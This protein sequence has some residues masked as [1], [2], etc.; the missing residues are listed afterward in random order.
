[1][2]QALSERGTSHPIQLISI[3]IVAETGEAFYGVNTYFNW[4]KASAWLKENVKPHIG[5][6]HECDSEWGHFG[7]PATIGRMIRIFV[8]NTSNDA[9]EFWGYYGAYDYVVLSQLMGGMEGWPIGWP[10][11]MRDLRQWLDERGLEDVKQSDDAVHNALTD[12]RWIRE[13]FDHEVMA[14]INGWLV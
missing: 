7:S 1:L 12:A 11:Y 4:D 2:A 13:T 8:E 14:V 5:K 6:A 3:G 9:P 10:Y